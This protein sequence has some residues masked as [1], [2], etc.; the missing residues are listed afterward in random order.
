MIT[1]RQVIKACGGRS[2]ST[3]TRTVGA[4]NRKIPVKTD[5]ETK[6]PH[7]HPNDFLGIHTSYGWY[8]I[9]KEFY[10]F[11]W[12]IPMLEQRLK[13]ACKDIDSTKLTASDRSR[14]QEEVVDVWS[15]T[16]DLNDK[17]IHTK[18]S[19]KDIEQQRKDREYRAQLKENPKSF[20]EGI[21]DEDG[22]PLTSSNSMAT[23]EK[24]TNSL[25]FT[26]A[27]NYFYAIKS[28]EA[29]D[30]ENKKVLQKRLALEWN[31]KSLAEKQKYREA[32][33]SL[34]SEG[35]DI[36][37]GEI[38][39]V[40]AK[41]K[42]KRSLDLS[43]IPEVSQELIDIHLP[44]ITMAD[45]KKYYISLRSSSIEVE[46]GV[47]KPTA[48]SREWVAFDEETKQKYRVRYAKLRAAGYTIF[49]GNIVPLKKE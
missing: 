1:I 14:L 32:Y 25:N 7:T 39:S 27:W 9:P 40:N 37:R 10:A 21:M 30:L 15:K 41:K 38:V 42:A 19:K 17:P 36:H 48:I 24:S 35:K 13:E 28:N 34:I 31:S 47:R 45:T 44:E 46:P 8:F 16:A 26:D 12:T 22:H 5:D 6:L 3:M 18:K 43:H 33:A 4:R 49:R 11:D 2:M 20:S 29:D 23:K